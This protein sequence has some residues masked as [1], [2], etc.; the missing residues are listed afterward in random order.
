MPTPPHKVGTREVTPGAGAEQAGV[1]P[2]SELVFIGNT[3][4][5]GMSHAAVVQLIVSTPR[6]T[7]VVMLRQFQDQGAEKQL[8]VDLRAAKQQLSPPNRR[9][10]IFEMALADGG[11]GA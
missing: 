11:R 1:L 3:N 10:R 5:R 2:G 6:P 9:L 8:R 4:V 7:R